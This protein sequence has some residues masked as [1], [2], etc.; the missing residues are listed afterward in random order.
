MNTPRKLKLLITG[1]TGLVGQGVLHEA[2]LADDVAQVTLLSRRRSTPADPRVRELLVEDF[3][4]LDK[5]EPSLRDIDACL[6]C[7]GAPPVS[8][9]EAEYRHVTVALTTSVARTLARL[10]PNMRFLYV[11]GAHANPSSVFMP[12]CIKGEV[13][14]A[15]KALALR[16]TMFRPGGIQ[17][18]HG[19][20][21]P[22]KTL[23]AIYS[24]A[25][26]L[27]GLGVSLTPSLVTTTARLGRAMLA[28]ARMP[29]PPAIVENAQINQL[30]A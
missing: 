12:L 14:V 23:R 9:P 7:A 19:E 18:V 21:S 20:R 29:D 10:S 28:V 3:E 24:V 26:P 6:Y 2:L 16:S 22:H 25:G 1:A 4:A 17:P 30:G 13:E 15:L 8:T 11:S 5:V 27:M